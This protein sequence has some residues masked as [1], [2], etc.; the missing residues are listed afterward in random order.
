M[1]ELVPKTK[2][3]MVV[4]V[5]PWKVALGHPKRIGRAGPHQ[6]KRLRRQRTRQT[7]LKAAIND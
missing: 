7:A 5:L 6:D 4:R 3:K 1:Y 2:K